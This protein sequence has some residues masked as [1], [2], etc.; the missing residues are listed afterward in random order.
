MRNV[1]VLDHRRKYSYSISKDYRAL[2]AVAES[3]HKNP[4]RFQGK[5]VPGAL[6]E[7]HLTFGDIYL[8]KSLRPPSLEKL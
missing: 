4:L 5:T 2:A 6:Y 8:E 3:F 7:T 1:L